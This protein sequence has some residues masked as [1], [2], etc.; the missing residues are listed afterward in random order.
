MLKL[1][2]TISINGKSIIDGVEAVGFQAQ[3]NSA[4][5]KEMNINS[6]H[7]TQEVY[8]ASRA[9]CRVDKAEFEDYCFG[10]QD[11]MLANVETEE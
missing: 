2:E 4:N 9:Q 5:P 7:T 1:T 6:W 3:I 11:K 8:K 10:V